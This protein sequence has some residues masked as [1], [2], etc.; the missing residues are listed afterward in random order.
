MSRTYLL[1][2]HDYPPINSARSV[3]WSAIAKRLATDGDRVDVVSAWQS[4]WPHEEILDGVRISRTNQIWLEKLRAWFKKSRGRRGEL[5]HT[6]SNSSK[7]AGWR[8]GI[9][10][11]AYRI[12][13]DLYKNLYWPDGAMPWYLP[14]LKQA[15]KLMSITEYDT[16]IS[17]SPYFTAHLICLRL[18]KA[19]PEQQWLVDIGDPFSFEEIEPHNNPLLYKKLNVRAEGRVLERADRISVTTPQTLE[20]Y[21]SLFPS[22]ASKIKVIPPLF[23][24]SGGEIEYPK[25]FP[26]EEKIRL[27]YIGRLYF[28]GRNPDNLLKLYESLLETSL[29]DALELHFFG[30]TRAVEA[31]FEPYRNLIGDKIYLHGQ[32]PH[33]IAMRAMHDASVLINLGNKSPYQ[34]PSKVVEYVSAGKPIINFAQIR[35]DTSERFFESYPSVINVHVWNSEET[36]F[37]VDALFNILSNLPPKLPRSQIARLLLPYTIDEIVTQYKSLL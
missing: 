36:D 6:S 2:T 26:S 13:H 24:Q 18:L 16:L 25:V 19:L 11:I 30:D 3:R 27:V 35:T 29:R 1:I 22:C 33:E 5:V 31:S 12:Y 17:A 10:F 14:A 28:E 8:R 21:V 23:V 4:D 7:R 9:S 37:Q 32:V 15:R 34:L 20:K